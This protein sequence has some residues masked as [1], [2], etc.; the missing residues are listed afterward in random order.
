[1]PMEELVRLHA[2]LTRVIEVTETDQP[3]AGGR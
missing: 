2:G 3:A 1:M